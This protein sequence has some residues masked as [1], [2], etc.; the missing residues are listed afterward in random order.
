MS[1]CNFGNFQLAD[2]LTVQFVISF[3]R[4]TQFQFKFQFRF[5]SQLLYLPSWLKKK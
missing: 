4:I 1:P 5:Q 3:L 2:S